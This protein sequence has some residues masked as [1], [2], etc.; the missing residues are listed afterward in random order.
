MRRN[1][2]E[3][4][5]S[6]SLKDFKKVLNSWNFQHVALHGWGEPLLNP[7]LFQMVKYAESR[8]LST[9]LTTNAT[10]IQANI[11]KIYS[12]YTGVEACRLLFLK[13][14]S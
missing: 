13:S 14:R 11:E 1:L 10:L 6:L 9:E 3:T 12:G 7:E 8:E 2:N 5:T 4:T